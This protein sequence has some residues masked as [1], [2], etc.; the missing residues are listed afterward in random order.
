V[1]VR[2]AKIH[3][4]A[5]SFAPSYLETFTGGIAVKPT[6]FASRG[7]QL[8]RGF[9]ALRVWMNL[10]VYGVDKIG[11]AIE[12]N[13]DDSQYLSTVIDAHPDLEL[14]A[15]T[16]M[17]VVCFRVKFPGLGEAELDDLNA[18]TLVRIQESGIAGPSNARIQ[19]RFAIRVAHTNHRTVRS[20]F[21]LLLASA[22]EMAAQIRDAD[23][24]RVGASA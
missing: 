24:D 5:F 10:S 9:R 7:I 22:L 17:N 18:R 11:A 4:D 6:E 19:G 12:Q 20:D 23:R 14:L 15:P 1:L 21:D 3:E 2:N 8:S 16:A 13:I